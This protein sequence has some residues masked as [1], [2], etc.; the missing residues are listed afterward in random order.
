M[1]RRLLKLLA[2]VLVA[3]ALLCGG[4]SAPTPGDRSA[5]SAASDDSPAG[6]WY[7]DEAGRR[8]RLHLRADAGK[9]SGD[10]AIEGRSGQP[11]ER[12]EWDPHSRWLSFRTGGDR[13]WRWYRVELVAG[14]LRGRATPPL[15]HAD[16]PDVRTFTHVVTGWH[17]QA[18]GRELLPRAWDLELADGRLA[19]LRIDR[20]RHA[21]D[22]ADD[23]HAG[24]SDLVGTFKVYASRQR[25]SN[26]EELEYPLHDIAWDGH[27]LRFTRLVDG[28]VESWEGRAD[29]RHLHGRQ[30]D[31]A[32]AGWQSWRGTRAELFGYGLAPRDAAARDAWQA[33]TRARVAHLL[34]A[35]APPAA[36]TSVE[37]LRSGVPPR[38][39]RRIDADRDDAPGQWPQ[40]YTLDELD[41]SWDIDDAGSGE[42][43]QRRG[44]GW[45]A[46]PSDHESGTRRPAVIVLNGHASSAWQLF[47]PDAEMYWYGDALARRGYI[48]LALDVSH[49]DY[50]DDPEGDNH[51][52]PA[53]APDG[54][55][56]DWEQDGERAWD[57]IRG[58]DHLLTRDDVDPERIAVF[59]LS[60][61]A[62][63]AL[64]AAALDTRVR[65]TVIAGFLPDFQVMAWNGNH[66]CWQWKNADINEY[67]DMATYLAL[68]AP[69]VLIAQSAAQDF[70]FSRRQPPFS[71]DKQVARRARIAWAGAGA[72]FLHLLHG[73]GHSLRVE[74]ATGG[75]KRFT[76]IEPLTADDLD[77]QASAATDAPG[78]DLFEVLARIVHERSSPD[79]GIPAPL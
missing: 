23:D 8:L 78:Q 33:T 25:H 36:T 52:H 28:R 32:G 49:R 41:F 24:D 42:R 70:T 15:D 6:H 58:I 57:V 17:A 9:A 76:V 2:P 35:G 60:L 7:L 68:I 73:H 39:S 5:V 26:A 45:L 46:S 12:I 69:R 37:V 16:M 18:F 59:G 51:A 1:S 14:V 48:V 79:R 38:P 53:I 74:S 34:M 31:D 62:E 61:G 4:C 44:H 11:I 13:H 56:S 77:W 43:L 72:N 50:G 67:V 30:R 54:L 55:T 75:V 29:G 22:D 47:D 19:R 20:V 64:Q 63:V 27:A 10:I 3:G 66:E 40:Q 65:S 21:G 71:A